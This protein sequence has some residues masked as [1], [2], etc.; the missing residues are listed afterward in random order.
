ML[1]RWVLAALHLV[2]LGLG[3]GSIANR[4]RTLSAPLDAGGFKRL[5]MA[6]TIWGVAALLWISTGLWRLLGQTEK[7]TA[8]YLGNGVFWTKMGFLLAIMVLEIWPMMT[9]IRWRMQVARGEPVDT[10]RAPALARI[11][12]VQLL[13]VIAMVFAATAMARGMGS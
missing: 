12:R 9:L 7:S 5:F 6:D 10:S 4:A 11:S 8:Y 2:A 1:L 3:A 13:L